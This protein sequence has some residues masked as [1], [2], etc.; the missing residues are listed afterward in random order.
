MVLKDL[1]TFYKLL[2]MLKQDSQFM[3]KLVQDKTDRYQLKPA[4]DY[5]NRNIQRDSRIIFLLIMVIMD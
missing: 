1:H 3:Q 5:Y 2:K 4:I